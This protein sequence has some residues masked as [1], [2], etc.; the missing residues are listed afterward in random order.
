MTN[1]PTWTSYYD[2][3]GDAAARPTLLRALDAWRGAP[4]LAIDLGCGSG[5]DTFALLA[6]GWRVHAIDSESEGL[7]RL[8]ARLDDNGRKRITTI[9]ARFED[10][11]FPSA[12]LVNASFCL[13]FCA[14]ESFPRVWQGITEAL[15]P[16]GLF[17]GHLFGIRDEW[18]S[19]GLTVHDRPEVEA[20]FAGFDMISLDETENEGVTAKGTQKRWHLFEIVARR[21]GR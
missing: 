5:R 19:C 2:A 17:A 11:A 3:V 12:D 20:L 8:A 6:G 18:A 15:P 9:C 1:S 16:G 7:K 13:P 21:I 4:G 14:P 10:V